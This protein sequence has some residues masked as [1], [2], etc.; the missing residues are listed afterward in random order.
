MDPVDM[1]TRVARSAGVV[2]GLG[3]AFVAGA[4]SLLVNKDRR[5]GANLAIGLGGELSLAAAGV[6]LNVIGE[7]NAWA[8]RPAVFLFNHQSEF[9]VPIMAGLLKKDFTAVAK[10]SLQTNPVFGPLGSLVGV[11]FIDRADAAAAREALQ[12]VVDSL[13]RGVS[14]VVAPEGTRSSEL[15]P[16]KKGP[17]HM[18][19]QG[20]VP[21]VP[22]VI[23]NSGEIIPAH[24]YLLK[25][26][27]VDVAV[28]PPVDTSSWTTETVDQHRDEV[29]QMYRDTLDN[30][31]EPDKY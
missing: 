24:S 15:L 25:P 1:V 31:P 8:A 2:G 23:R 28:L 20:Q 13:A 19:I 6:H 12:P 16:F 11:A 14:I 4:T 30:W 10:K 3:T 26:G 5:D 18:A 21:V 17:F 27:T 9:D 29:W 22:V 7:E